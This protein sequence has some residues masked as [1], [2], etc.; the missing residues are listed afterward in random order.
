[1]ASRERYVVVA[2]VVFAIIMAVIFGHA[3]E[4]VWIRF[5]LEDFY[6]FSMRQLPFTKVLPFALLALAAYLF[7]KNDSTHKLA[8]EVVDE[9]Y[10][11]SWPGR[12]ETGYATVVVIIATF[13][14]AAFLGILD[15]VWLWVTDIVLGL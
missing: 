8:T 5:G 3:M 9:L 10:K 4:W 14:A 7:L 1:M 15:S 12:E 6:L 13:I 2:V 11:V